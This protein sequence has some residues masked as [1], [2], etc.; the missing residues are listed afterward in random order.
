MKD[1]LITNSNNKD[2]K[3]YISLKPPQKQN[4]WK[5]ILQQSQ[6][7]NKQLQIHVNWIEKDKFSNET[8]YICVCVCV[9]VCEF[10]INHLT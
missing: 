3:K 4:T 6:L 7:K 5:Y 9:P 10:S 2:S 1:P 8:T